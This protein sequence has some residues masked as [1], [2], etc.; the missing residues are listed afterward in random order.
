MIMVEE[1]CKHH[2]KGYRD[3][4]GRCFFGFDCIKIRELKAKQAADK[5]RQAD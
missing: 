4:G 2:C 1:Y 3:T 5:Y